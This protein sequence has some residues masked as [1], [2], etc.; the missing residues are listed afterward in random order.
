[1]G[2]VSCESASF[3]CQAVEE[4]PAEQEKGEIWAFLNGLPA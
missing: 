4:R 1:L 3:T 2:P